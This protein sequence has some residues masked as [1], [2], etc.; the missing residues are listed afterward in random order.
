MTPQICTK[1]HSPDRE[2]LSSQCTDVSRVARTRSWK[3]RFR[4]IW[5]LPAA[6]NPKDA[7]PIP[8]KCA[9]DVQTALECAFPHC[10]R[11]SSARK[12]APRNSAAASNAY[13][14]M[15]PVNGT[16]NW[17]SKGTVESFMEMSIATLL[18]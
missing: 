1:V 2:E 4:R 16:A 8:Q 3:D 13:R 12:N 17:C 9:N 5:S 14:V 10:P 18:G 15:I 6:R 11:A 7:R